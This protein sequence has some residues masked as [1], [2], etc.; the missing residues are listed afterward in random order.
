MAL[1][2]NL[3]FDLFCEATFWNFENLILQQTN[4]KHTENIH[5]HADFDTKNVVDVG[6]KYKFVR[7]RTTPS[8]AAVAI[9]S[10]LNGE[11]LY[12]NKN[13]HFVDVSGVNFYVF[14]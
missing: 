1:E 3:G 7:T 4:N 12:H 9:C 13:M 6:N 14:L 11:N 10:Q 8:S 2:F 5:F